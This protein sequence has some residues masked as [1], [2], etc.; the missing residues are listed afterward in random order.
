M[1]GYLTSYVG[2]F[3]A[4]GGADSPTVTNVEIPLIQRD[5]AQGRAEPKAE[6]IR[7]TFLEVLLDSLQNDRPMGLDFVY[8]HVD[9]GTLRPLDGQQR[10]TTLFLLH[11]YI[12]S[13]T[14]HLD[15]DAA[16][17]RLSYA[18]RPSA[19]L[20]CKRLAA[21]PLPMNGTRPSTWITDQIWYLHVWRHDPTIQAMLVMLDAIAER[22]SRIDGFNVV[23]A[24]ARLIDPETP[25]VW[26]YLLPLDDMGSDEDLYIKMNSRGK[27]LTE[28]ENFKARFEKDIEG[29]PRIQEFTSKIDSVWSDLL[30]PLH[31]GDNIV[32]D[33]FI[34]YIDFVTEISEFRERRFGSGRLGPRARRVYG[35]DNERAAEHLDLLFDAFDTW[36]SCEE[37][38]GAFSE[39]F[40]TRLPGQPGYDSG[41]VV[42]FGA[43][44]TNLL[45]SCCR[46]FDSQR[47][48]SRL[49]SLQQSLLLYAVLLHRLHHTEDF[50]R[51]L[52]I[53]RNLIAASEDEIRRP[54]MPAL[55]ADTETLVTAGDLSAIRRFS[56]NQVEDELLKQAFLDACPE[57]RASLYQLEDH[58]ILRGTLSAFEFDNA[59]FQSR[60]HAFEQAFGKPNRWTELTGAI[61]SSGD[62]Q[63]RRP[64]STAW[65]FGASSA[66]NEPVWRYLL[67]D[68]PRISLTDTRG[69]LATFLDAFAGADGTDPYGALIRPWI[70]DR[71]SVSRLDWRYYLVKYPLMRSGATGIYF[72]DNGE[73]SYTLCM[74]RTKQRNGNYRDPLLLQIWESSGVGSRVDDPWFSGY[75]YY[76]RWLRFSRSGAA[77]RNTYSA[78]IL[79]PPEDVDLGPTFAE[80]CERYGVVDLKSSSPRFII[81]QH[82]VD[83]ELV[84]SVNRVDIGA[85][86]IQDL[87]AAGL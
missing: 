47:A 49:F 3:E 73:M 82:D 25:A 44:G 65:Q 50:P 32:D 4:R 42:L 23:D 38:R 41:K 61:L 83:G 77:L 15:A 7:A 58:P 31:G 35:A 28:F 51:R 45:E 67:T 17:T 59:T 43:T 75:E 14:G 86:L 8:G 68:A 62:Y 56:S 54:N 37:A 6:E 52:R 12:A 19:R 66:G 34:R 27:P 57:S 13:R 48:A 22:V 21:N 1:K 46:Q 5:Y 69:V 84:D 76:P 53:L 10:L 72:A 40:S 30:W 20:F 60:A 70:E 9:N 36:G 55:L 29:S 80:V 2:I 64:N 85:R 16:W 39:L 81:P 79:R 26:L 18:T 87:V 78:F 63:R 24:W 33:E 74:L 11:W 71:E